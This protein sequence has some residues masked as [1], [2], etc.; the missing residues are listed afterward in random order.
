MT[1]PD[2]KVMHAEMRI[3]DSVAMLNNEMEPLEKMRAL[4]PTKRT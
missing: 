3:G 4:P 2:G 1:S